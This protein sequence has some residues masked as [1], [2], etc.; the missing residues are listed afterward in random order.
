MCDEKSF[1]ELMELYKADPEAYETYR[2]ET[3]EKHITDLCADC[4]D[5]LERCLQFQW[6]LEQQLNKFKDPI[7]RYNAIVSIFWSQVSEFQNAVELQQVLSEAKQNSNI[8][9]FPKK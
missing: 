6:Q 3:I 9:N 2:K 8:L 4:P 7:A 5:R 1:D